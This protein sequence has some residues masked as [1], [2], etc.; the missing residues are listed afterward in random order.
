MTSRTLLLAVI[1]ACRSEQQVGYIV[2]RSVPL[3]LRWRFRINL[4]CVRP[5]IAAALCVF[6]LCIGTSVI[7]Y[8]KLSQGLADQLE[9]ALGTKASRLIRMHLPKNLFHVR[10]ALPSNTRY[11]CFMKV[12]RKSQ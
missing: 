5:E 8:S 10:Q 3:P 9:S 11:G 7:C 4:K 1:D 12:Q 6:L 2:R